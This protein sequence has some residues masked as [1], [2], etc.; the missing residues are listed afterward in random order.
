MSKRKV[1]WQTIGKQMTDAMIF[2]NKNQ[3]TAAIDTANQADQEF[4]SAGQF[5][6]NQFESRNKKVIA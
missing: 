1:T 4:I 2:K 3:A 6:P 5:G